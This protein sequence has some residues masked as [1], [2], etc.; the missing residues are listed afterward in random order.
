MN[1]NNITL[2]AN[3]STYA[4]NTTTHTTI[5]II[6]HTTHP[7]PLHIYIYIS[8]KD[9]TLQLVLTLPVYTDYLPQ[10]YGMKDSY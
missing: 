4:H 1:K 9:Y 10:E 2:D 6:L 5:I 7:R 3:G 8:Q